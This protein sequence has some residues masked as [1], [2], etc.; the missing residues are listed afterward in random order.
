[1]VMRED[2]IV[3]SNDKS[4]VLEPGKTQRVIAQ[5]IPPRAMLIVDGLVVLD[6]RDD[7]WLPGLDTLSVFSWTREQFDNVRVYTAKR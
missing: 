2:K 3:L 4:P 5:F 6:Y 1:V 7:R